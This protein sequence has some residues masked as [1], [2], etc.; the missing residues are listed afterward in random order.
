MPFVLVNEK[1]TPSRFIP[2]EEKKP[3]RFIPVEQ[4]RFIEGPKISERLA[5][6]GRAFSSGTIESAG[7]IPAPDIFSGFVQPYSFGKYIEKLIPESERKYKPK[8]LSEQVAYFAGHAVQDLAQLS[9]STKF[10]A[11]LHPLMVDK[12]LSRM[13]TVA[14][15][16]GAKMAQTG[17][18]FS[19]KTFVNEMSNLFEDKQTMMG[20]IGETVKSAGLG[21]GLGAA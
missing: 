21:L 6:L 20:L 4:P 19:L 1:K 15:F 18:S 14:R 16:T 9:A 17:A 10:T 12:V 2:V 3:S 13:P 11:P 5:G 8:N 7:R